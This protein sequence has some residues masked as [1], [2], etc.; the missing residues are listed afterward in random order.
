VRLT[1]DTNW[2]EIPELVIESYRSLAPKNLTA[3][4]DSHRREEPL[5]PEGG[6][7]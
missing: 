2:N 3:R 4:L 1:D 6:D 7:S 5:E